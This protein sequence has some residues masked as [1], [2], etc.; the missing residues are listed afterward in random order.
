MTT[1]K[2]LKDLAGSGAASIPKP[3]SH[4]LLRFGIPVLVVGAAIA[5]L[6]VTAWSALTPARAV[7]TITVAVRPVEHSIP[8]GQSNQGALIQAPGW[9]EPDPFT[10]YVPALT[11][12]IVKDV[13]VLEGA[14]I[15]VGEVVA[16]LVDDDAIIRVEIADANLALARAKEEATTAI[17][18]AAVTEQETLVGPTLRIQVAR[19]M[20][21]QLHAEHARFAAE[22]VAA[23][24][25]REG[26]LDEFMRKQG[27]VDE[28]AVAEAVVVRLQKRV[29]ASSAAIISLEKQQ[30]ATN[31]RT[32][33][34]QAETVAAERDL[35]LQIKEQLDVEKARANVMEAA[36]S[37]NLAIAARDEALLELDRC[38]VRSPVAGIVIERLTSPGST[39][40]FANG[41][42]GAHILHVYDPASL[43]VRADIPLADASRVGV[44]QR[45]EIVIDLLPNTIFEGEVT[46]FLHKADIQKNTVEAKVRIIDPSPLLKPEMLA[47]VRILPASAGGVDTVKSTVQRVFIPKDAITSDGDVSTV[48]MIDQLDRGK[49][50]AE[51]RSILLG[52]S[53]SNGWIEVVEGLRPGDKVILDGE[54]LESGDQVMITREG[55]A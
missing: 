47:R 3:P 54:G 22:I 16:T 19:A 41:T 24:A 4:H 9:V 29:D 5:L 2:S 30:Q 8:V 10:T 1:Q 49:G 34:A 11:D 21:E 6:I 46:R 53:L 25:T 51:N 37:I 23:Q 44:G 55:E 17:L 13:L 52:E 42:H 43:Q 50:R 28:G 20:V 36:A 35:E 40:N 39:V 27:L 26:L 33:A 32:S 31:A 14:R 7:R 12:G 48:W 45:A 15:E 38:Q 18:K